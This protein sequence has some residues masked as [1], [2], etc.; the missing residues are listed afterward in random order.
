M[1][2]IIRFEQSSLGQFFFALREKVLRQVFQVAGGAFIM[3]CLRF[4]AR[5]FLQ[6]IKSQTR[7]ST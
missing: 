6:A 1:L 4:F 2:Q 7:E 5:P 3:T